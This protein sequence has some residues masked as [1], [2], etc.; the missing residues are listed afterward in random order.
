MSRALFKRLTDVNEAL[1]L[2]LSKCKL[3]IDI[4]EKALIEAYGRYLAENIYAPINLPPYPRS[5][6]DGYAV[7]SRD[8]WEASF[9][10]PVKLKIK[11]LVNI[12]EYPKDLRVN[13][14]EAVKVMTG[15]VI[16]VGADAVV[17][18]E[19]TEEYGNIV[20]V[21][22]SVTPG[23][24]IAWPG[25]DVYR[26]T[27]IARK[28]E[29]ITPYLIA[30]LAGLGINKVKVHRRLNIGIISTGI[31]LEKPGH[32][33]T[34][35]KVYDVNSYLLASLALRD[36]FTPKT[37]GII[38]DDEQ[39]LEKI[40]L[41]AVDENDIVLISGGTSVGEEDIVYRV[42]RRIGRVLVHGLKLKPG[43]P[44]VIG[45]VH[46]K[47]VFGLPGNPGS[48]LNVY[49]NLVRKYLEKVHGQ[50]Q[51]EYTIRGILVRPVMGERGRKTYKPVYV[52][53]RNGKY[54][55]LPLEFESYMISKHLMSDGIVVVEPGFRVGYNEGDEVDVK[56]Y[57]PI[58]GYRYII[59]GEIPSLIHEHISKLENVKIILMSSKSALD[60]LD[61]EVSDLSI[62]LNT[63]LKIS[64]PYVSLYSK[65]V[66]VYLVSRSN[67]IN[68]ITKYS[69]GSGLQRFNKII[70]EVLNISNSFNVTSIPV[71]APIEA[72]ILLEDGIVDAS[73]I[74]EYEFQSMKNIVNKYEVMRIGS[75]KLFMVCKMNKVNEAKLLLNRV[76]GVIEGIASAGT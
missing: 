72:K 56:L 5:T 66:N 29:R 71:I 64:R 8:T 73:V 60:M 76:K 16:P 15:S 9:E 13:E 39:L 61:K 10:N 43:K 53:K 68:R 6:V 18:V 28:G 54:L 45:I 12:G 34:K 23:T 22:K 17:P 44:T 2:V 1:R 4:E 52:L 67:K 59:T 58:R 41:R 21:Y 37:Y 50:E 30:V 55:I 25:S 11:G 49:E 27:L 19:H 7:R 31:E 26:G 32:K 63:T 24:N 70:L 14:R 65:E 57:K 36:G 75:V 38:P 33:L 42:L 51:P 69:H 48:A 74:T 40:L 35:G 3:T 47:P 62:I 20:E 46:N